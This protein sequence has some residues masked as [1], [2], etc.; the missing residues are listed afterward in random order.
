MAAIPAT[1]PA[2]VTRR[3]FGSFESAA[4]ETIPLLESSFL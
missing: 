3:P 2:V 1:A 4:A